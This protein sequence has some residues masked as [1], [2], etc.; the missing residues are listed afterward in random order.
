MSQ[1]KTEI[2]NLYNS[3]QL[4]YESYVSNFKNE[5]SIESF[6][7][8]RLYFLNLI[9]EVNFIFLKIFQKLNHIFNDEISNEK[10]INLIQI[11]FNIW[12]K[13]SKNEKYKND[14]FIFFFVACCFILI[15]VKFNLLLFQ[16]DYPDK[17]EEFYQWCKDNEIDFQ[18]SNWAK[19]LIL[20]NS[21]EKNITWCNNIINLIFEKLLQKLTFSKEKIF[22]LIE[23][24]K[25]FIQFSLNDYIIYSKYN[26]VIIALSSIL[27]S[28]SNDFNEEIPNK[29]LEINR[30]IIKNLFKEFDD[31]IDFSLIEKCSEDILNTINLS[32]E[33]DNDEDSEFENTRENSN[34]SSIEIS[35]NI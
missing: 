15:N 19:K 21:S 34:N 20:K 30:N 26:Q 3:S 14:I 11:S 8:F 29:E 25:T 5:T 10:L 12:N 6:N 17:N 2:Q 4:F 23:I 22:N 13:I 9:N 1:L 27:S 24:S 28:L 31:F 32:L 35:N 18:F 7:K 33:K 16:K